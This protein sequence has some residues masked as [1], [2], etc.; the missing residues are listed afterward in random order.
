MSVLFILMLLLAFN[1]LH[2]C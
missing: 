1:W 2:Y